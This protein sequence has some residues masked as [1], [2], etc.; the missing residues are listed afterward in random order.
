M[1]IK[2]V[3]PQGTIFDNEKVDSITIPT[4]EGIITVLDEHV[5]LIS[6]MAAGELEVCSG[7]TIEVFAISGGVLEVQQ[8][9]IVNIMADTAERASEINLEEAEAAYKRAQEY[10]E[11]QLHQQDVDFAALQSVIEKELARVNVA[12]KY[13]NVGR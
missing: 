4:K 13:R 9:S 12:R 11:K 2:V 8:E 5:P 3:T 10:L 6:I 1:K 7:D